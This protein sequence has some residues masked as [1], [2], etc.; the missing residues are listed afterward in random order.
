M[1]HHLTIYTHH[2]YPYNITRLPWQELK[3]AIMDHVGRARTLAAPKREAYEGLNEIDKDVLKAVNA[4]KTLQPTKLYQAFG[5]SLS[6]NYG[7]YDR[8]LYGQQLEAM[9]VSVI[10]DTVANM[11]IMDIL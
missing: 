8:P 7:A 1:D 2:E 11:G 9:A 3:P 10:R 4:N 5:S 6:Q